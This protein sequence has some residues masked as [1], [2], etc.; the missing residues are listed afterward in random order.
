[1]LKETSV[2]A[3]SEWCWSHLVLILLECWSEEGGDSEVSQSLM[4]HLM[5]A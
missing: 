5:T 3:V 1:M 4:Y 2:A